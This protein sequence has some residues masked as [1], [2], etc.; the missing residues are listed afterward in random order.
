MDLKKYKNQIAQVLYLCCVL[1]AM[2]HTYNIASNIN[3]QRTIDSKI[4]TSNEIIL[5]DEPKELPIASN[6]NDEN[7][8]ALVNI[9]WSLFIGGLIYGK[10]E[11]N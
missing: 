5:I 8:W 1:L 3:D 4:L 6:K 2:F 10:I 9:C 11:W 7:F